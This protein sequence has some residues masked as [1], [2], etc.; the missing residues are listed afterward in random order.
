MVLRIASKSSN[1]PG[2]LTNASASEVWLLVH[3]GINPVFDFF[4]LDDKECYDIPLLIKAAEEIQHPFQRIYVA[5]SSGNRIICVFP[6]NGNRHVP[7]DITDPS[8]L[9][10]LN[11]RSMGIQTHRGVNEIRIG[12]EFKPDR[13]R[14]LPLL[15][16]VRIKKQVQGKKA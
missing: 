7:P 14:L 2:Y 11:I 16:S 6:F 12:N 4:N 9:R 3:G 15:D 8:T 1:A 10:V 5:S 13:E